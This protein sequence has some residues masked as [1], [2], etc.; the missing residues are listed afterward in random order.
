MRT[1]LRLIL[2]ALAVGATYYAYRWWSPDE[3]DRIR[4]ALDDLAEVVSHSNG[5]GLSQMTRAARL[6]SFF[7]DDVTVDLGPPFQPIQG[8]DT[9]MALAAR[10]QVPGEGLDVRFVDIDVML[11]ADG[12]A[13]TVHLTATVRGSSVGDLQAID[14]KELVMGLRK[15]DGEWR[16]DRVTGIQPL[17][18]PKN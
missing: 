8:R 16:I 12:L 7:A 11:R 4:A 9:I 5:G 6:G 15:I 13:A 18:R 17:E 1:A 10:A 2:V 14:A 3:E